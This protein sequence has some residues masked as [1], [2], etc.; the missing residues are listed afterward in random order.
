MRD[1]L[2]DC[3]PCVPFG[4]AGTFWPLPCGVQEPPPR[5]AHPAF[6]ERHLHCIWYDDRL[7][8]PVLRT[9]AGEEIRVVSP[10]TWNTGPGPDFLGAVFV[11]APEMRRVSGD[12]EIHVHPADW[13]R[14]GHAGDPRYAGIRLHL[15][16]TPGLVPADLLPPGTLQ[17]ALQP[18]LAADPAFSFDN[19]DLL[20]YPLAARNPAPPCQTALRLLPPPDR[21]R[22]LDIAGETRLRRRAES[23]RDA[24]RERGTAQVVWEETLA[25][26][27]YRANQPPFRRLARLLPLARLRELSRGDPTAAYAILMGLA[28]LL[29]DPSRPGPW[30]P[31][32]RAFLR[33]CWDAWWPVAA[34]FLPDVLPSSAWRFAGL[35]PANHPARRLMAAAVL[36]APPDSLPER[37]ERL[38]A[39]PAPPSV[40]ECLALFDL[41]DAP[42]W[43][44]RLSFRTPPLDAPVALV[45]ETRAR[46]IL[47]NLLFP[48]FAVLAPSPGAWRPFLAQLPPE[49]TNRTIRLAA[50]RLL[51]PDHSPRLYRTALRRQG[52]IHL[53]NAYCL[54]DRTA[55]AACPLPGTI[56]AAV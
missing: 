3:F 15:T 53:H 12:V 56:R 42:Y 32:T 16:Y 48:L 51:G 18:L 6:S 29:P 20:A 34:D 30:D 31:E 55:C 49:E 28:G 11:L 19:I 38:A 54:A 22:L 17:A 41:P 36:F 21:G 25:A 23:L 43:P 1:P 8:P 13:Q 47:V 5:P 4:E 9:A 33:T 14:H 26:L 50:A 40:R 46:A 37:V 44:R 24:V 35:R 45:G 2:D 27:G 52:L 7:R 10:G 39:R